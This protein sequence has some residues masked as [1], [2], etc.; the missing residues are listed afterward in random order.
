MF[1]NPQWFRPKAIGWGL[2]PVSFKGWLYTAG[3]IGAIAVPFLLLIT[4][5]QPLEAF[6]WMTLGVGAMA[7]DVRQILRSFRSTDSATAAT[8]SAPKRDDNVLYIGDSSP[9]AAVATANYNL[10]VR[11]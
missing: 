11:R 8:V 7:Y 5:G 2:V 9:G 1:G 10:R 4:R 3:W 6:A